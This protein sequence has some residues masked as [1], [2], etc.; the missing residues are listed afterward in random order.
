MYMDD[1]KL[2]TENE[3]IGNSNTRSKDIQ[4]RYKDGIW[5][6]KIRHAN[7]ERHETTH[8]RRNGIS[9]SIKN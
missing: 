8:D 6:R 5:Y 2:F 1:T 9:R 7:N 3:R 4:S